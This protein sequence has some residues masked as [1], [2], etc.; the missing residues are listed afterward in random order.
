MSFSCSNCPPLKKIANTL[1]KLPDLDISEKKFRGDYI[2][3]IEAGNMKSS[4]MKGVD[5]YGRSFLAFKTVKI[6]KETKKAVLDTNTKKQKEY[7]SVLFQRLGGNTEFWCTS[8]DCENGGLT[9][10]YGAI[11]VGDYYA[12]LAK[13]I[14]DLLAGET[15]TT[16][17]G[18]FK[19]V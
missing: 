17:R 3:F 1:A 13:R 7:V 8:Q 5:K 2:D 9:D 10:Y 15:I 16:E 14:T 6:D 19:L 12:Y 18:L 11:H 4:A